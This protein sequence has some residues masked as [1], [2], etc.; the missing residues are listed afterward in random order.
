MYVLIAEDEQDTRELLR[1]YFES[2]GHQVRCAKDGEEALELI[3]DVP[4]DFLLLDVR[5]PG[6][7][8]WQVLQEVRER[9]HFPVLILSALAETN[10]AVR[11]LSLGA[12]DYLRK[13][14]EISELDARIRA[15]LRRGTLAQEA[16]NGDLEFA[17]IHL[18]VNQKTVLINDDELHLTPKEFKLLQ[19]LMTEPE[20]VYSIDEIVS[21]VWGDRSVATAADVKQYVMMLRKKL[22]AANGECEA[23][24][25]N[26]KGHGYFLTH[27]K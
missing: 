8:G 22:S 6:I 25:K 27:S 20:R 18:L 15:V 9:Y 12:D 11:G 13:P 5:M 14:F 16:E 26:R 1:S 2:L 10:D 19:M 3:N 24:V 23:K 7:D 21:E 17:G 4:P